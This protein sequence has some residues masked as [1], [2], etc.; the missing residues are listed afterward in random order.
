MDIETK[1]YSDNSATKINEYRLSNPFVNLLLATDAMQQSL[2]LRGGLCSL[3][4]AL[5]RSLSVG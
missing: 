3:L 2:I 1:K 4:L 5:A